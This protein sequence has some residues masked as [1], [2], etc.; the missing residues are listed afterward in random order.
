MHLNQG[1]V[2]CIE[3]SCLFKHALLLAA[4]NATPFWTLHSLPS[5]HQSNLLLLLGQQLLLAL[6]APCCCFRFKPDAGLRCLTP[7]FLPAGPA[8]PSSQ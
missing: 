1:D 6:L 5:L 2:Y 7:L 4:A 3:P 8:A